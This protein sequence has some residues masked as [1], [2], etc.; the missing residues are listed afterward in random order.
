[1]AT[2]IIGSTRPSVGLFIA[3]VIAAGA[4]STLLGIACERTVFRRTF[5]DYYS[6]LLASF[7]LLLFLTGVVETFWGGTNPRTA[8][9]PSALAGS[10]GIGHANI[11]KYYFVLLVVGIVLAATIHLT[12]AGTWTGRRV[13]GSR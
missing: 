10:V 3:S 2:S 9:S 11:P 5:V 13:R 6:G 12:L 7:A 8:G 4:F 1:M